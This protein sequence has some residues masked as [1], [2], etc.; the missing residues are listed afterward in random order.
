MNTHLSLVFLISLI[1]ASLLQATI[2]SK[3]NI[4]FIMSDDHTSQAVGAYGGRLAKLNPTPTIDTLAAEGVVLENAFAHNAI[5]TPSRAC[6]MTGQYSVINGCLT[7]NEKLPAERQY[8]SMEMK[9]AGYQTA[10]VGKWHLKERPSTFDY[11]KVLPGQGFYFDPVF[12]ESGVKGKIERPNPYNP[13]RSL[14]FGPD[15]V[16]MTG[17]STDCIADS[18]LEWLQDKRDPS[19]PFFLKLHF[20]APHDY[21]EYA[22]RYESYLADVDIPEPANMW[23][24]QNN[25]SIATRGHNDELMPYIGTSVGRRNLR[26][27]YAEDPKTPWAAQVDH[28]LNDADIKRQTYQLYLKAYLRCVKGVDDNVARVI[29]YLKAEGLYDNTVI[30]YTGDQGFYLG[31]H[32]Y[33]DK[34]WAYEQSMRMP[35]IVRY[36]PSIEAKTRSDAIVEN[37]DFAPT[38]LDFAG[39]VTPNYMQGRSFKSIIESGVE[40]ASWKKAAYYHYAMHMAHHDNPAHIAIRTK[41]HKLIMFYGT[42]WQ[43]EVSPDT[44]PA[45]ELYDLKNDPGE[46]NNVYDNPEYA[47]VV[48]ELKGQLRGLRSEYKV[49]GPEFA[50]N[51]AI[52][53]FWEYDE[54]DRARAMELSYEVLEKHKNGT[55]THNVKKSAKKN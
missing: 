1:P 35:L 33:I 54:D 23:D 13:N 29:A 34:R 40:P 8:L 51:K 41:R 21:F 53:D 30:I 45:W 36:P 52:E 17:H 10:V 50:Y 42:D 46:D 16:E 11:F 38:M 15:A 25:G 55:W 7:L 24:I 26:R 9:K 32:D 18:A 39:V 4:I 47:S 19:K 3:P 12:F 31:E 28:S 14:K 49:D 6:I 37:V 2:Q 43:G 22:P 48:A 27:N 5:C 20:K 44:P